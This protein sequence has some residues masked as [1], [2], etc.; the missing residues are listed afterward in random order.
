MN[1][2]VNKWSLKD[3]EKLYHLPFNDLIYQAQ[4]VHRQNHDPNKIQVSTLMSIKTGGCPEDCKYCSQSIKY[5]TDVEIEKLLTVDEVIAQAKE[6][7]KSGASRFCM[8][9]AW[10]NLNDSNISKIKD[11]VKAVKELELETCL[12]LGMLKKE[13]AESLK[14]SGLDYYNHNLDSSEEYY[15]KVVSTR[16]YKD[17]LNTLKYVRDAGIKVCTGGILGLGEENLDRL[18]LI[19]VLCNMDEQP[20][21]VP[22]NKLVRIEGTPYSN[23]DDVDNFDFIRIIAITRITMPKTYVRLSAGRDTMNDEMQAL[24]FFAG[25]NSIFYGEELLTT[26][27]SSINHDKNLLSKLSIETI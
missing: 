8:G 21:S 27:N 19:E 3:I 14:E 11:M 16:T 25:A 1:K 24:C 20:E 17:R 12:T 23:N 18:K 22:M 7:K 15:S 10:R 9:A 5:N 2:K 4:T 26:K 6:A 13:Q